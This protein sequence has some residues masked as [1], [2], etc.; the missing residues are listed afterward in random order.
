MISIYLDQNKWIEMAR[1]LYKNDGAP[2]IKSVIDRVSSG[3]L[4]GS[5]CIPISDI[6]VMEI[7]KIGSNRQRSQLASLF[8]DFS[9]GW[10]FKNRQSRIEYELQKAVA[11]AFNVSQD[12]TLHPEPFCRSLLEAFG[13]INTLADSMEVSPETLSLL[14]SQLDSK[15]QILSFLE[16]RDEARRRLSIHHVKRNLNELK[17]RIEK[18]RA[19]VK[20]HPS[21]FRTRA[22]HAALMIDSQDRLIGALDKIKK[23]KHD[24]SGLPY[25]IIQSLYNHVPC[26]DVEICLAIQ[27]EQQTSRSLELNDIYDIGALT[28]AIP[29]CDVVVTENLWVDLASR[30]ELDK[31][32]D[33]KL[34]SRLSQLSEILDSLGYDDG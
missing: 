6:H 8:V 34:L 11:N 27:L 5:I 18:R 21:S 28:G 31:K 12:K 2:E 3:V 23:T 30:A 17:M 33:T 4:K 16:F 7:A 10:F 1:V 19:L 14:N 9:N 20:D 22:Y 25:S 13:E 32:Y 26:Y 15:S 29:Y 24:F